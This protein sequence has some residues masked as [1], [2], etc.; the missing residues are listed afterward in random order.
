MLWWY[1]SNIHFLTDLLHWLQLFNSLQKAGVKVESTLAEVNSG[2]IYLKIGQLWSYF[3][4]LC[5]DMQDIYNRLW[6]TRDKTEFND[7]F[8]FVNAPLFLGVNCKTKTSIFGE[9]FAKTCQLCCSHVETV[10]TDRFPRY[11]CGYH[12]I[13]SYLL[14]NLGS[15]FSVSCINFSTNSQC[16]KWTCC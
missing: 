10:V 12:L 6:E 8:I 5:I 3:N 1:Y 15:S 11:G 4:A 13:I 2:S 7:S 14:F 9:K 16:V